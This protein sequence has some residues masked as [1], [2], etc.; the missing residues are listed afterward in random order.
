M[1][2]EDIILAEEKVRRK[3]KEKIGQIVVTLEDFADALQYE[4]GFS[5]LYYRFMRYIAKIK[6]E[7]EN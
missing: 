4:F 1:I 2:E 3:Y 5:D 6:D 7:N